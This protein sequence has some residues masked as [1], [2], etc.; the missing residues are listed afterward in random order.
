MP[1]P[2]QFNRVNYQQE[3]SSKKSAQQRSSSSQSKKSRPGK[4]SSPHSLQ[5]PKYAVNVLQPQ[6]NKNKSIFQGPV[7]QNF[8]KNAVKKDIEIVSK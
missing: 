1:S 3:Y 6:A 8:F 5:D 7:N 4:K 2:Q